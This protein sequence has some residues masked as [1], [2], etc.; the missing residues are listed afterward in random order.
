MSDKVFDYEIHCLNNNENLKVRV[1]QNVIPGHKY[2]YWGV[3]KDLFEVLNRLDSNNQITT[4]DRNKLKRFLKVMEKHSGICASTKC[5]ITSNSDKFKSRNTQEVTVIPLDYFPLLIAKFEPPETNT[6]AHKVYEIVLCEIQN[7]IEDAHLTELLFSTE[8][9]YQ[10]GIEEGKNS[11]FIDSKEK[12]YISRLV[13]LICE[14]SED[15]TV[16]ENQLKKQIFASF[17][18]DS[19]YGGIR[20]GNYRQCVN[21]IKSYK[22]MYPKGEVHYSKFE[23]INDYYKNNRKNVV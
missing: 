11:C 19:T 8:Q 13:K 23:P 14:D 18:V 9:A 4:R 5:T 1:L 12:N 20:K 3:T 22:L 17:S 16:D 7:L 6:E 15:P 2:R 10:N 21:F